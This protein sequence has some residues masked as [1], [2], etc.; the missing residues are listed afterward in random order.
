ML[1]CLPRSDLSGYSIGAAGAA[2]TGTEMEEAAP[3]AMPPDT[4]EGAEE[5]EDTLP[6]ATQPD[7]GSTLS[8]STGSTLAA[9]AGDDCDAEG[10]FR[11]LD[12]QSCY[13]LSSDEAGWIGARDACREWGGEL[14][15]IQ[16]RQEDDFLTPRP[17]VDTWIGANDRANEGIFVWAD[18]TPV[19]FFNWSQAQPDNFEGQENCVEI[20]V[21]D[22]NWNDRPCGG[23][24]EPYLC[25][26]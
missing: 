26:R 25:E 2:G 16:S 9:D 20:R 11:S 6:I 13:L 23:D 24:P 3:D 5:L 15:T 10:E 14:A 4:V 22:R 17:S 8:G 12:G 18:G 19:T 21:L 1:G 7:A